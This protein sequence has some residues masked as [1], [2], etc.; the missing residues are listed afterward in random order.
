MP[1]LAPS[2]APDIAGTKAENSPPE[3]AP[4]T[5]DKNPNAVKKPE[6]AR[7][8]PGSGKLVNPS[9][10]VKPS[11]PGTTSLN[12]EAADIRD[13]AKTILG[14]I[15]KESYI[16]DPKVVGTIS[17][18]TSNPLPRDALL[19]TLETVL[20]MNGAVLV[21]E[22]GMYK[23]MP[24]AASRGSVSPRMGSTLSGYGIQIVPL[25]YVGVVEMAKLLEPFAPDPA[26]VKI[27]ELRNLLILSGT[28]NEIQHML[29]TVEMF[30]VD[31]LSGM[32]IGLFTLQSTDIKAISTEVGKIFGD[33]TLNPLAGVVRII[34]IERL[35]AF[36]IITP[37]AQYL[38]QAKLWLERLDKAGS[39]SGS[40]LY[41]YHVQN[42]KA[43]YLAEL[44]NQAFASKNQ[45]QTPRPTP[46]A[47]VAPGMIGTD[48]KPSQSLSGF[49]TGATG[50]GT[51]V[52]STTNIAR[53][54][55][56]TMPAVG[57]T[58]SISDESGG[59]ASEVRVVADKENNAL[60]ILSNAAGYEK[61]ETALKKLDVAPRQVLIEVVIAEVALTGDMSYGIDW[62]FTS[63]PR[64]SGQLT[65]DAKLAKVSPGFSYA[66]TN[67]A[68]TAIQAVLN[69]IAHDSKVNVLSSPHIMVADNQTAKIQ[70]GNSVPTQTSST[71]ST[72][73]STG[74]VTSTIQYLD[75]GVMLSVT[76]HIN[77]GGLVNLDITQEVS[78]ANTTNTSTLNSPTISRRSAKTI[79]SVQS[80]ETMVMGGLISEKSSNG[81]S[82]LPLLSQIPIL[83]G[84]FG[85]QSQTSGK[86]E[87]IMLITPRVASN[88][89]QGKDISDELRRKMGE[90]KELLECGTSNIFG[91]TSRGGLWCL[92]P[93]RYNGG[94]DKMKELDVNQQPAY[95]KER[96]ADALAEAKRQEAIAQERLLEAM[97]RVEETQRM[98]PPP[99]APPLVTVPAA[100][101]P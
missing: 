61:I 84:A 24:S 4:E 45:A 49:N 51:M 31:W 3:K 75:T 5:S 29:D 35:N 99:P 101:Q 95:K 37:Q 68:G 89:N 8:Y 23:I 6:L 22:N 65:S 62:S 28:Q 1:V 17:F 83:G 32:S 54:N 93:N 70:V 63:G 81:S 34:P 82:G 55:T 52:G 7:M 44:L 94:I 18:R 2:V 58:L 50:T 59:P 60:L 38:E 57:T 67:V 98:A 76:P 74:T 20:R 33:K 26:A 30:D 48:L 43:E 12:F 100:Q 14:E 25:R 77:A 96:A 41:V 16:V 73:A 40:R 90:A 64:K 13:I 80:G 47:S 66:L 53:P 87:L 27:D 9:P 92:E 69:T 15:L 39:T 78:D 36:V 21:K 10:A 42:G 71:T 11:G 46:A 85:Q 72:L 19:P 91:Y 56:P 79:V 86:T 88:T 97:R